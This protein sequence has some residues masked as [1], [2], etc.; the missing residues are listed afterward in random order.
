MKDNEQMKTCFGKYRKI[1]GW[2]EGF[3]LAIPIILIVAVT[4]I[5][6]ANIVAE[7]NPDVVVIQEADE[8][9]QEEELTVWSLLGELS[10]KRFDTESDNKA[11]LIIMG[12][13]VFID[14]IFIICM[15]DL[16]KKIFYQVETKGT[17]FTEETINYFHAMSKV[18]II[19]AII[20]LI[21]MSFGATDLGMGLILLITILSLSKVFEYGYDLQKE[22]NNK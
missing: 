11:I 15:V 8:E 1:M 7:D 22:V 12:V 9:Y 2:F 3:L 13:C 21:S 16:I 6:V 14:Y 19:L 20:R 18:A 10:E 17:P 4:V 5:L